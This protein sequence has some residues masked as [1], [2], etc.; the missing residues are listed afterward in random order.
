MT[1]SHVDGVQK[2]GARADGLRIGIGSIGSFPRVDIGDTS[3]AVLAQTVWRQEPESAGQDLRT[4]I[5]GLA[6]RRASCDHSLHL[7]ERITFQRETMGQQ[8]QWC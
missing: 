5:K 3:V 1:Q 8:R 4:A 2:N 7:V 6:K